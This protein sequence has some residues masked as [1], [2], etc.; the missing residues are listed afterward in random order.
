MELDECFYYG[1]GGR[2]WGVALFLSEFRRLVFK[3]FSFMIKIYVGFCIV[4]MW[5]IFFKKK[6]KLYFF[7]FILNGEIF[8]ICLLFF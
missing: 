7:W 4:V 3:Y 1:F 2:G 8:V 6:I 5:N